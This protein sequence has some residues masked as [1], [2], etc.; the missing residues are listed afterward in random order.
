[1]LTQSRLEDKC[2]VGEG[3]HIIAIAS[4]S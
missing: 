2:A 3:A 4:V 1:L